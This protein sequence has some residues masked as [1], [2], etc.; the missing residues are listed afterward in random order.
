MPHTQSNHELSWPQNNLRE[1]L[2]PFLVQLTMR[3]SAA[4]S[5]VGCD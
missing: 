5:D 2:Q 3:V 4:P 1:F